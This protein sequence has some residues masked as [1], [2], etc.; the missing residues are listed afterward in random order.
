VVMVGNEDE[1]Q[2]YSRTRSENQK[3]PG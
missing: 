2:R 3:T 1:L